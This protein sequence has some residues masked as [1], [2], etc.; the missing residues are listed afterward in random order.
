MQKGGDFIAKGSFGGVYSF[1]NFILDLLDV[2]RKMGVSVTE[3]QLQFQICFSNS[4]CG[5]TIYAKETFD[6][7]YYK[8]YTPFVYKVIFDPTERYA[9]FES[10][11]RV[12]E[13]LKLNL[14]AQ[15]DVD[16]VKDCTI[17]ALVEYEPLAI[18]TEIVIS[19][20]AHDKLVSLIPYARCDGNLG[21]AENITFRE[22]LNIV[23]NVHRFLNRIEDLHHF[24]I[25]PANILYKVKADGGTRN[26]V[27]GDYGSISKKRKISTPLTTCPFG[28][29]GN[30]IPRDKYLE[31]TAEFGNSILFTSLYTGYE[32]KYSNKNWSEHGFY[33]KMDIYSLGITLYMLVKKGQV[34]SDAVN[35]VIQIATAFLNPNICLTL[36]E[37]LTSTNKYLE[38]N[39]RQIGGNKR[40][41]VKLVDGRTRVVYLDDKKHKYI[42]VDNKKCYLKDIRGKYEYV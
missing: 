9:E 37:V 10:L 18:M 16:F 15:G 40:R 27:L 13:V 25:K 24:D 33:T 26:F 17:L 34:M 38:Q 11:Q 21:D 5:E 3:D 20:H 35:T 32:K 28:P 39:K 23:G 12:I 22:I 6:T 36:G 30:I 1:N 7:Y 2:L 8:Y 31:Y 4:P 14:K 41:K 42:K 19:S 29:N